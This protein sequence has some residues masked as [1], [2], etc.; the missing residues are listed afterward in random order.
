MVLQIGPYAGLLSDFNG[1]E[2]STI[3]EQPNA[4]KESNSKAIQEAKLAEAGSN[5]WGKHRGS[6][7]AKKDH[8]QTTLSAGFRGISWQ[9]KVSSSVAIHLYFILSAEVAQFC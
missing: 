2:I 3:S 1:G 5:T 7:K 4:E 8:Y 6:T 9:Q